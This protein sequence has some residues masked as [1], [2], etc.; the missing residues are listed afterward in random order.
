MAKRITIALLTFFIFFIAKPLYAGER[1]HSLGISFKY[2]YHDYKE[3]NEPEWFKSNETGFLPGI[4]ITYNY[5][6]I[7]NPLYLRLLFEYEENK[8]DYDGG[9]Q[10]VATQTV[11][12]MQAKT[13]NKFNTWEGNIGFTFKP[14]TKEQPVNITVYT[15]IGYRYWNRGLGGQAPYSEE[16]T[17]KYIPFGVRAAYSIN[18]KWKGGF[19][20][21][22]WFIYDA[23]I[24]VN[25]SEID[26]NFNNP[27]AKLGNRM[28]WKIEVP[29]IYQFSDRWSLNFVPSY[30]NYSFGESEFFPITYGGASTSLVAK[31]PDSRTNIYSIRLGI[32][33]HF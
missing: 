6:G 5:E 14:W 11:T 31:E 22:A 26:P 9:I 25:F 24:R 13:N 15:G 29:I 30:E 17:W 19:E 23:E 2:A 18:E 10:D 3:T 4:Q 20:I 21:A 33:F 1:P 12:P 7:K 27:I 28:G 8:T 16:Y 32:K